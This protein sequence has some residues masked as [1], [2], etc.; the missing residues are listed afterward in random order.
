MKNYVAAIPAYQ[1]A[2]TVGDVV[3]RTRAILPRVLV[4]D[5]GSTD[6]TAQEAERAGAE[7]HRLSTN[8]GKGAA[9]LAAFEKLF[10]EGADAVVTLDADGQHLPEEI[11][12]LLSAAPSADLVL[13]TREHLFSEMSTVRATSNRLSSRLISLVAGCWVPDVQTGFRRYSRRLFATTGFPEAHFD[14]ESAVLV[15]AARSR[16]EIATVQVRLGIANN[17]ANTHYRPVVDS[18]RIARAVFCARFL[19]K[20]REPLR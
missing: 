1:A 12:R 2:L 10:I 5:D 6:G 7:V 8:R 16:M 4:V 14:A 13:G 19:D 3:G 20:R 17:G 15:R 11:P 9:L 18:V